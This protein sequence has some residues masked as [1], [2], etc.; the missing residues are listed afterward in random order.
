[1][2]SSPRYKT[3][4]ETPFLG[5]IVPN[6]WQEPEYEEDTHKQIYFRY[7]I[8]KIIGNITYR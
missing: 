5:W 8:T 2:R 6:A 1:M 4:S 3:M 7:S